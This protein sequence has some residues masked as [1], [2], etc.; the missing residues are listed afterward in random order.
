MHRQHALGVLQGGGG[1]GRRGEARA[2]GGQ[3]EGREEAG[4]EGSEE[5]G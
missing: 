3:G 4:R 1:A 2:E 5:G